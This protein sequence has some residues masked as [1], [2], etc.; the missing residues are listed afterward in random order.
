M[1][2]MHNWMNLTQPFFCIPLPPSLSSSAVIV[3]GGG[4]CVFRTRDCFFDFSSGHN[5]RLQKKALATLEAPPN[6]RITLCKQ[7]TVYLRGGL[8]VAT[9]GVGSV[10]TSGIRRSQLAPECYNR[11]RRIPICNQLPKPALG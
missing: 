4:K 6:V 3:G 7:T 1:K 9:C 2:I 11:G 5:H 10:A 8:T